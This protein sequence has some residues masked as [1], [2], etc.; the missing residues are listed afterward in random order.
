MS[1]QFIV[2]RGGS[3]TPSIYIECEA[4]WMINNEVPRVS[5]HCVSLSAAS[6][7]AA[8]LDEAGDSGPRSQHLDCAHVK[9]VVSE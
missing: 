7:L 8:K 9:A 3:P 4:C 2:V 1:I 5:T 6:E